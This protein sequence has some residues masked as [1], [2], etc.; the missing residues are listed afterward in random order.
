MTG[1]GFFLADLGMDTAAAG[2]FDPEAII[3]R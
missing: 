3:G 2:A 1:T